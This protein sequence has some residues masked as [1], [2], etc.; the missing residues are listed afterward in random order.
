MNY[1]LS[2][3]GGSYSLTNA[4][5]IAC[6]AIIVLIAVLTIAFLYQ[7]DKRAKITT[8]QMVF[9]AVM[10]ALAVVTT[11]IKLFEL[12]YGGSVTLFSMLFVCVIGYW[13]GPKIGIL[14]ATIFSIL[15]FVL[16]G[17]TYILSF[18]QVCFDYIFAFAVLG[19]AGFFY[20][21][22]NG[23][24]IGYIVAILARGVMASIAGYLYWM[25]YMPENFPKSLA[26]VYPIIYNYSYI[27]AEGVITI[28]ILM[29]PAVKKAMA[30]SKKLVNQ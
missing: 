22:K 4:G 26:I 29:I 27:L 13:Y 12:P 28:I 24:V 30:E 2:N 10:L 9:V 17:S 1:F 23:L 5:M 16:G 18:W 19:L 6:V 3:D 20:K 25:E 14:S 11:N 15:Q 8:K 21:K 7:R